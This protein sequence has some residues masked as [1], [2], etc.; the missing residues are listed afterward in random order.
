M[1][2]F[3]L[4]ALRQCQ[5]IAQDAIA[6]LVVFVACCLFEMSNL[7]QDMLDNIMDG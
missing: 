7:G 4:A 5:A 3:H 6:V 2:E 1:L